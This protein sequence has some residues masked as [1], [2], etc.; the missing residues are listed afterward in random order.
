MH[1][2]INNAHAISTTSIYIM[3]SYFL[4]YIQEQIRLHQ[5][6]EANSQYMYANNDLHIATL[7]TTA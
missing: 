6:S 1:M 5:L 3:W 2:I 4:S 7:L